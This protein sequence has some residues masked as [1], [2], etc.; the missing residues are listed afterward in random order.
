MRVSPRSQALTFEVLDNIR[1]EVRQYPIC[2]AFH[3][4]VPHGTGFEMSRAGRRI[5]RRTTCDVVTTQEAAPGP[6]R[7]EGSRPGR[8]SGLNRG[9]PL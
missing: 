2:L 6:E 7:E 9:F 4:S 5:G 3:G 1:T 8:L